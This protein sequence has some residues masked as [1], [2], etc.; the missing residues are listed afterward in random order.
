MKAKQICGPSH[1]WRG[2]CNDAADD[3][4]VT[5]RVNG[6]AAVAL[7]VIVVTGFPFC[8]KAHVAPD[9]SELCKQESVIGW[10]GIPVFAFKESE[11]VA[12]PPGETVW[13][14][15]CGPV[16]AATIVTDSVP[17]AVESACETASMVMVAGD[18]TL[19]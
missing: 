14:A 13:A 3:G 11:Y 15:G 17:M 16:G 19:A 6:T 5:T 18:G 1:G 7:G 12:V 9:G 10:L 8:E 2:L 4:T